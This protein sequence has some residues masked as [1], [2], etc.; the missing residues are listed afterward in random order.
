MRNM[1]ARIRRILENPQFDRFGTDFSEIIAHN[2]AC[3]CCIS[4]SSA[5]KRQT[6]LS[7]L[8]TEASE[9]VFL[10]LS[11]LRADEVTSIIG[12]LIN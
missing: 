12:Q 2:I 3:F 4:K 5:K 11:K 9:L 7:P 6:D 1:C 8:F 10:S